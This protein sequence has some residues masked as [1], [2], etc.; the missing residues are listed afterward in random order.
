M[1]LAGLREYLHETWEQA[2]DWNRLGLIE[3]LG[4]GPDTLLDLGCADG[5]FTSEV[6]RSIGACT[7]MGVEVVPELA[8]SAAAGSDRRVVFDDLNNLETVKIF[9]KGISVEKPVSDFGEFQL[10]LRDGDIISPKIETSEPLRNMCRHFVDCLDTRQSPTTDG[11]SGLQT[12]KVI[13]AI[14]TSLAEKGC[15]VPIQW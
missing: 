7:V 4:N 2:Q 15:Y 12:V 8:M 3:M 10:L 13:E 14:E 9:E 1:A 11:V 6:A 5:E